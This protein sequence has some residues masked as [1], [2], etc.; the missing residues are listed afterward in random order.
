MK[1]F[2]TSH[3]LDKKWLHALVA[4]KWK[5]IESIDFT[6]KSYLDV[7]CHVGYSCFRAWAA[8]A[9]HFLGI[10]VRADVLKVAEEIKKELNIA[11]GFIFLNKDWAKHPENELAF[12][13]VSMLGLIHYFPKKIYKKVLKSLCDIKEESLILELRIIPSN[14]SFVQTIQRQTLPSTKWLSNALKQYGF[15]HF[16]RHVRESRRELW[17]AKR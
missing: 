2:P 15:K 11:D 3:R 5:Y 8:S 10:D 6:N 16:K 17:I 12:D 13:I 14:H 4:D 1:E 7:G 9:D